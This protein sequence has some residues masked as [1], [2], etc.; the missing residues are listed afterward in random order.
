MAGK[1]RKEKENL[2]LVFLTRTSS[3]FQATIPLLSLN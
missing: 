3:A 2:T 1:Y